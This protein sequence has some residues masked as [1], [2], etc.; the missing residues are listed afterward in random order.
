MRR[1]IYTLTTLLFCFA[2]ASS[3]AQ[4]EMITG[5]VIDQTDNKGIEFTTL[6][7]FDQTDAIL[8]GGTVADTSGRFILEDI[9]AGKYY[10]RVSFIGYQT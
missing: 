7:L 5:V 3:F 1:T 8:V 9:A 6:T 4:G 10:L 2:F